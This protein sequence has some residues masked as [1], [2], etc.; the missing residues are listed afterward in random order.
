MASSH[1]RARAIPTKAQIKGVHIAIHELKHENSEYTN[2]LNH[3][4][5][6]NA[7]VSEANDK[8]AEEIAER[9]RRRDHLTADALNFPH[10]LSRRRSLLALARRRKELYQLEISTIPHGMIFTKLTRDVRRLHSEIHGIGIE[11]RRTRAR[12]TAQQ[13]AIAQI[14][15][16]NSFKTL[17]LSFNGRLREDATR[18]MRVVDFDALL[19]SPEQKSRIDSV[20]KKMGQSE[21]L[22]R[23]LIKFHPGLETTETEEFFHSISEKLDV[24]LPVLQHLEKVVSQPGKCDLNGRELAAFAGEFCSDVIRADKLELDSDE[25]ESDSLTKPRVVVPK[26]ALKDLPKLGGLKSARI[27]PIDLK[28]FVAG[29]QLRGRPVSARTPRLEKLHLFG[30]GSSGGKTSGPLIS[31]LLARPQSPVSGAKKPA[32]V[33]ATPQTSGHWLFANED[34]G[35][36]VYRS[37]PSDLQAKGQDD[38]SSMI[39]PGWPRTI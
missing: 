26:I 31:V 23:M 28:S 11:S 7:H 14:I 29:E 13:A 5:R 18:L 10:E 30:F 16:L 3:L 37:A 34:S 12:V 22:R 24:T 4:I 38:T 21:K 6:S 25:P 35:S 1:F 19:V 8:L 20:R 15:D 27:I 9:T 39:H 17:L 33:K 2:T 32:S 36:E